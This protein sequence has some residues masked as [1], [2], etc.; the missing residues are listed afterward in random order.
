MKL[1]PNKS[2]PEKWVK[3]YQAMAVGKLKPSRHNIQHGQ[4][5]SMGTRRADPGYTVV[6]EEKVEPTMVSPTEMAKQQAQSEVNHRQQQGHGGTLEARRHARNYVRGR[7]TVELAIAP[8]K[9]ARKRKS[10][11][12]PANPWRGRTI[13][14]VAKRGRFF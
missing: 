13:T 3:F 14:K 10:A 11:S 12:S 2:D 1:V 7:D 6:E 4:G 8:I 5:R 9:A